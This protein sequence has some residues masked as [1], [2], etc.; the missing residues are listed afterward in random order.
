MVQL[1]ILSGSKA[2]GLQAVR[3]FP[4]HIGRAADNDLCV[5]GDGIWDYHF[6]LD[7]RPGEG[8]TFQTFDQAF[9]TVNDAPQTSLTLRNGDVISFGSVKLQFWLAPPVQRGLRVRELFV[10]MLL[11]VVS[12]G[13]ITLISWLLAMG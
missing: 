4:F 1:R 11:L 3:R 8:F 13:Q 5:D 10:W 2:G 7:L 6:M 9:A 12:V